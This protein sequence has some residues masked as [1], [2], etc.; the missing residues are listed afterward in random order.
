MSV[1]LV[2]EVGEDLHINWWNWRPILELMH[3]EQLISDEQHERMGCN[4]CGGKMTAAEAS[5][6]FDV[7]TQVIQNWPD[8]F[9]L[10]LDGTHTLKTE[11]KR[12]R[13]GDDP[14]IHYFTTRESMQRFADFCRSCQGFEVY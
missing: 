2:P 6:T 12:L 7:L 13:A 11:P 14:S 4:G 8:D 5:K 1:I 9:G 10:R 3:R